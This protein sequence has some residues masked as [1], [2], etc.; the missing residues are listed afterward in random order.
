M[1][2]SSRKKKD[3]P[4][5]PLPALLLLMLQYR[6]NSRVFLWSLAA[7]RSHSCS[8]GPVATC[9]VPSLGVRSTHTSA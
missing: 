9:C 4:L 1:A 3:L 7:C 5:L 8:S 2:L 6:T